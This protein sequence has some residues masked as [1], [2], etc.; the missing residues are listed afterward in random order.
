MGENK[1]EILKQKKFFAQ[2][3]NVN[4]K[5]KGIQKFIKRCQCLAYDEAPDYDALERDIKVMQLDEG[6]FEELF[7]GAYLVFCQ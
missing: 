2:Q 6:K 3:D 7:Q 4:S 1:E 5:F